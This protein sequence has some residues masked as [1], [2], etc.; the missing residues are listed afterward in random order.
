M[1]A[2]TCLGS[3]GRI[4]LKP[5]SPLEDKPFVAGTTLFVSGSFPLQ[6]PACK[7]LC[8]QGLANIRPRAPAYAGARAFSWHAGSSSLCLAWPRPS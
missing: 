8:V 3:F 5:T 1:P 6:S 4:R 2:A 7:M